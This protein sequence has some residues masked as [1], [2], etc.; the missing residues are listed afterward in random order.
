MA[1]NGTTARYPK[2]RRNIVNYH[3][4]HAIDVDEDEAELSEEL[5]EEVTTSPEDVTSPA[6]DESDHDEMESEAEDATYGSRKS[7]KVLLPTEA[8]GQ[9]R[10]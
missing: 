10:C 2:R 6:N 5:G 7:K 3:I 8:R 9:M 4:D 1:A